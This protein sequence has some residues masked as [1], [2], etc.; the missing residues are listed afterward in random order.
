[1][2]IIHKQGKGFFAFACQCAAGQGQI[3]QA[4]ISGQQ[5]RKKLS[6]NNTA[7][8]LQC[9]YWSDQMSSVIGLYVL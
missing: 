5:Q 2:L 6:D 1:M 9:H 3:S 7:L 4:P 8:G